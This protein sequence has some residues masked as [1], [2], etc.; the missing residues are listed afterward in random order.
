VLATGLPAHAAPP[1]DSVARGAYL[2]AAAGCDQCH[3]DAKNE[4]RPYAGGR[5]LETPFGTVFPPNITP[6]PDTGIGRWRLEDFNQAMRW[7]IAPDD[8]HDLPVFPFP[9]YN[10]L[11]DGDLCDLRSFLE[12]VTAV[13]LTNH[14][15][16]PK[17]FSAAWTRAAVSVVAERFSGPW[18]PDPGKDAAFNRGAY[19][20]ATVGRCGDCHTPRDWLGAPNPEFALSGASAGPGGKAVPNIT[21]ERETGIGNWSED[22]I[23][24][25]LRDGQTPDFDFVGGAM[26]EIVKNTSRLDDADR[27]AIAVYLRA[28]PAI[29]S[30]KKRIDR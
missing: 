9:F 10:R 19:L 2:A 26:A 27:R 29:R 7:G 3:T 18:Q 1:A 25:L 11:T 17:N 30:Q 24:T 22:D 14:P 16:S 28:I 21:P 20:V 15:S 6:D 8:S 12:S 23:V 4:G 5:A 13:S